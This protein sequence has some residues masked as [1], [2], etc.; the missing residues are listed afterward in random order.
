MTNRLFDFDGYCLSFTAKVLECEAQEDGFAVVLDATAFAPEGGGQRSDIGF[1]D[2]VE[3]VDAWMRDG[4]IYHRTK[5]PLAVGKIVLGQV[6]RAR[7]IRHIQNHTGEHIVSGLFHNH[8]GFNNVGFHLGSEDV[9]LDL[10]GTVDESMLRAIEREAN[11]IVVSNVAVQVAYPDAETLASLSYRAK[12]DLTEDVR[13]VT[14]EGV[15]ACACCAPHVN[16]TGEIGMIKLISAMRYKGGTRIHMKCGFDALEE[17]NAE[18]ARAV[19]ISNRISLPRERIAEGVDKLWQ[20]LADANFRLVGLKREIIAIK[21]EAAQETDGN[22]LFMEKDMDAGELR[23]LVSAAGHKAGRA[24]A[25]FC[26]DGRGAY[27]FVATYVGQD[28]DAWRASLTEALQ[29][30]GGGK[31]PFLQGKANC[32]EQEIRRFFAD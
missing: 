5:T 4:V 32:T 17:F 31:A 10:D 25:A 13:I 3:V 23:L 21:A 28:F 18:Y 12:L 19:A 15:D 6:D 11:E 24:C 9:T 29:A 30:H 26:E 14:I 2:G 1:L 20:D 22:L 27:S 7:R 8:Y 16:R